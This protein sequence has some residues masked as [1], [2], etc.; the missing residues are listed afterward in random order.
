[1]DPDTLDGR[2]T[3]LLGV[4][5]LLMDPDANKRAAGFV[6]CDGLRYP[7]CTNYRV[8]S[9]V[10]DSDAL[11]G[12]VPGCRNPRILRCPEWTGS[13]VAGWPGCRM[14]GLL[15]AVI[16]VDSDVLDGWVAG[17]RPSGW[18][19]MPWMN[20]FPGVVILADS[21]CSGQTG[22]RVSSVVIDSN[23]L[24]KWVTNLVILVYPIPY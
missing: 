1:M 8:S 3:G 18:T 5:I 14:D 10:M 17:C 23:T 13:R 11:G 4:V 19:P 7:G 24:D 20:G 16:L 6:S 15:G 12:R 22:R 21:Q 9:F 2:V